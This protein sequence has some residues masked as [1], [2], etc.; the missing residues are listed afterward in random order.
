MSYILDALKRA[1]AER[2]H[3]AAPP[4]PDMARAAAFDPHSRRS[5]FRWWAIGLLVI[6]L[7]GAAAWAWFGR[8]PSPPAENPAAPTIA[9]TALHPPAAQN[10]TERPA[11]PPQPEASPAHGNATAAH[12]APSKSPPAP[13]PPSAPVL[14]ILAQAPPTPPAPT[15]SVKPPAAEPAAAPTQA[16]AAPKKPTESLPPLNAAQ[17]A[18]LPEITVS[19]SSYSANP[20]HRMLIANGQV[21]KEGQE[22]SPGLTLE[23]IGQRSAVF[24]QRGMRFNVNY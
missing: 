8:S 23:S 13:K 5:G 3:S 20:A 11:R 15:P 6:A 9:A 1:D 10:G 19:G 21:V 7:I 22:L 18:A 16:E 2:G 17:R 14:P 12:A 24:N 4:T